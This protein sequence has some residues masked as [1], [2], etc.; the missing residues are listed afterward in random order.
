MRN[1]PIAFESAQ[2]GAIRSANREATGGF[3][4]VKG[5]FRLL[6]RFFVALCAITVFLP[7]ALLAQQVASTDAQNQ[8]GSNVNATAADAIRPFHFKASKE[9]LADL[10]KRI[11]A[12]RWPDKETVNDASQGVQLA[13]GRCRNPIGLSRRPTRSS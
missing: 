5:R 12:T 4:V 10:R 1:E 11:A 2:S 7:A 6:W 8:S 3:S 9:A 13:T